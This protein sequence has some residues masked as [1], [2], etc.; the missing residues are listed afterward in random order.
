MAKLTTLLLISGLWLAMSNRPAVY[1][2]STTDLIGIVYQTVNVRSGPDN[3]FEIVARLEKDNVVTINGRESEANRWLRIAL[4][5]VENTPYGWVTSFSLTVDGELDALPIVST[6]NG[7]DDETSTIVRVVAYGRINVR[8][9]PAIEYDVVGQLEAE[10]EAN[11]LA[12]SNRANDWLYIERETLAGWVAYFTVTVLGDPSDL[13][14][15]VPNGSNTELIPPSELVQVRYNVRLRAEPSLRSAIIGIVPFD[16]DTTPTAQTTDGRWLYVEY[17]GIEGWA[18]AELFDIAEDH[19]ARLP[20]YREA[21]AV[22]ITPSPA[23]T[24]PVEG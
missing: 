14:V 8:S 19:H 18:L 13:P 17:E 10:D 11:V 20:I 23:A 7:P 9:G 2:Q 21:P 5:D 24:E 16:S 4:E 1:A 3:R 15:R 12:R 6:Q 22:T